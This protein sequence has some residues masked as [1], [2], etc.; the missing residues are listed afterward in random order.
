MP[1]PLDALKKATSI[2]ADPYAL[3]IPEEGMMRGEMPLPPF[4]AG[5]AQLKQ[6][7]EVLR[8]PGSLAS[9]AG[10]V[11]EGLKSFGSAADDAFKSE[12]LAKY[13]SKL[14]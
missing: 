12:Q 13:L 6:A 14:R 10:P 4:G 11:V 8:A 9:Y 5:L 3:N 7:I 2:G 1:S